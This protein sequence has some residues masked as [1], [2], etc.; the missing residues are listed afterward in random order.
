MTHSTQTLRTA[1]PRANRGSALLTM[2]DVWRQRQHLKSLDQAA[3]SDI[4]LTRAQALT[5]ATRPVWD[6]PSTWRS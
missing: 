5:E 2:L 6:V 4:G 3:L 1:L